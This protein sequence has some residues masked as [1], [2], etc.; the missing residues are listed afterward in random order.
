MK[1]EHLAQMS[2]YLAFG[3][4]CARIVTTE[5]GFSLIRGSEATRPEAR[6]TMRKPWMTKKIK[7]LFMRES[8]ISERRGIPSK[9]A[10]TV[11]EVK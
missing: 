5:P 9:M 10:N 2:T 4:F 7:Y 3:K 11:G 8:S 6:V 1:N